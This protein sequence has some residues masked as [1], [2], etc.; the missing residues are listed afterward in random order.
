MKLTQEGIDLIAKVR[1][2]M[3]ESECRG[4]ESFICWNLVFEASGNRKVDTRSLPDRMDEVGGICCKIW[5]A[6]GDALD[7]TGIMETYIYREFAKVGAKITSQK[8]YELAKL[9]RLAWLDRII[10]TGEIK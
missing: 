9:A 1:D 3:Y 8:S 2:R 4:A 5:H 10:E 6:I 7:G